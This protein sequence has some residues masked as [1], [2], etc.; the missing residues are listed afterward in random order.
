MLRTVMVGCGG[1]AKVCLDVLR[2]VPG[3]ELCGA[4]GPIDAEAKMIG[5]AYLGTDARLGDLR[6]SNISHAF[7]ALGDN[8]LR[9]RKLDEVRGLGFSVLSGCHPAAVVA[10]DVRIGEG[11]IIM[12]GAVVNP[13]VQIGA[14]VIV[15]TGATID[16]DCVIEDG[17]HIAPGVHLAGGVTIR[18][19][20]TMGIGSCAIPGCVVGEWAFVGAGAAVVS[21]ISSGATAV[22]VPARARSGSSTVR[23]A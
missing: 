7:V 8:R 19:G 18:R 4:T 20:V 15:N 11:T 17:A 6:A 23:G 14:G 12:A 16:H 3:V 5:L 21:D 1:H 13:G 9:M 10:S 2:R 22:G